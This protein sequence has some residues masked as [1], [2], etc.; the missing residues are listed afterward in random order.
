MSLNDQKFVSFKFNKS[1]MPKIA[2]LIRDEENRRQDFLYEL[3]IRLYE[4]A[5]KEKLNTVDK[6]TNTLESYS[7]RTISFPNSQ[8]NGIFTASYYSDDRFNIV[9]E[10][11]SAKNNGLRKPRKS[12]FKKITSREKSF[13]ISFCSSAQLYINI[14]NKKVVFSTDYN[15]HSADRLDL[16]YPSHL[17][18]MLKRQKWG[19]GEGGFSMY[20][21]ENYYIE[22]I[23][24]DYPEFDLLSDCWGK[25]GEQ[26]R[27]DQAA[28]L[29]MQ[30]RIRR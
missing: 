29:K 23:S 6:M 28:T 3:A 21:S 15:N 26:I 4:F 16:A 10:L 22:H 30:A 18:S 2:K 20:R 11:Y 14:E 9:K 19:R 24:T 13:R 5:K 17:I 27:K 8:N 7:T 25:F 12:A 1:N